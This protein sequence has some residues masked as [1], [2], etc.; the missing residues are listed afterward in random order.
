MLLELTRKDLSVGL[1]NAQVEDPVVRRRATS[2][3]QYQHGTEAFRVSDF[4][5]IFAETQYSVAIGQISEA[6][7]GVFGRFIV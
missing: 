7:D 6:D 4:V 3:A 1:G 5:S 2:H